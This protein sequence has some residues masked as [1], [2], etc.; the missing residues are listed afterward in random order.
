VDTRLARDHGGDRAR[1]WDAVAAE[2]RARGLRRAT[3]DDVLDH[4]DH[5][6]QV[7]G[8]DHVGLGSDFDGVPALPEGL[9]DV[10]RL[11]WL[12]YGLLQRGY[13]E[14]DVRKILGGNLLRVLAEA[15]ARSDG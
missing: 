5:I 9:E 4:L 2:A 10:T 14:A 6:A 13:A 3:L 1:L 12:T 15:D 11:P 8:V 7:A